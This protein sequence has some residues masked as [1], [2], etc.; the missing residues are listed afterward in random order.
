[1]VTLAPRSLWSCYPHDR[2][3]NRFVAGCSLGVPAHRTPL[4]RPVWDNP[5]S[6]NP[7]NE[8]LYDA[9]NGTADGAAVFDSQHSSK[10]EHHQKT[11]CKIEG[12]MQ[13]PPASSGSER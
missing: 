13:Y 10:S 2:Q 3:L 7:P 9:Q 12:R 8:A 5:A 4:A 11:L 6:R 1:M